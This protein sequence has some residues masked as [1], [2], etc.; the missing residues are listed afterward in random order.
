MSTILPI[1][2]IDQEEGYSDYYSP[3]SKFIKDQFSEMVRLIFNLP[4]KNSFDAG[5]AK[6]DSKEK[7]DFLDRQV[8]EYSR[9]VNL[10][11]EA[12]IAIELSEDEIEKQI[13]NLKS[14]LEVILDSGANYNDALNA[15]DVLVINIRKRISGLDDEIDSIEKSIFSFDQIIGE[16]NTEI[17]TLNLNEAAR[18][19]FLSFNEICGSNDCKLF[20]SSSKSYAKNLLY[21]KDQIK[22]LIRNQESDKIKIEQL[23]QRRDEEI[24]YLHSVIEERGESRENNEIEMLVHAVSQIKDDIFELQDKKRKIVEYR[25]CQNKYYEKYNERDKVLKEHESFTADRRSNPDLIKVRTGIRQKFLDWLDIINTQNI[26][27][28]ITFTNDFGP[29][30]GAETIKQ[31]RGS[32][33]VRAVLSFHAALIDLAV[34]NSKCSLNLFIMDAPKQ[35]E[36][37]NKELDDFIKALKNISQDKHTQVIFSATEYKYEGDDNDQVWVPLY[38]GEKQNMFMKSNDKNGDG[39]RL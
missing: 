20:S 38:P 1:Y 14:E 16:I 22:D 21:L 31:L 13:S 39:A 32:T 18:R 12:V 11:K 25:L 3:Q 24:E 19:V 5:Q 27:R 2:Y 26:V 33:K 36:L 9:Q 28:D 35:H 17:D 8:E 15:L 23:K 37:P 29:I 34:T 30:L 6:R 7:L 10:A 4:V